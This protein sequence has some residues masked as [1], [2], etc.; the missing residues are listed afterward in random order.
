[1]GAQIWEKRGGVWGSGGL[2]PRCLSR[3]QAPRRGIRRGGRVLGTQTR[4]TQTV[5]AGLFLGV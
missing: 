3:Q 2:G 4:R 1:M 5:G